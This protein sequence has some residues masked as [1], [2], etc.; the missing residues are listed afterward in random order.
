MKKALVSLVLAL[1]AVA[2]GC[3][4]DEQTI[5]ASPSKSVPIASAK[6]TAWLAAISDRQR[7]RVYVTWAVAYDDRP[8][9]RMYVAAS[10]DGGRTFGPP[11]W[12]ARD[13]SAWLPVIR[14]D[15]TGR[16]WATW[17]HFDLDPKHLLNPKDEYSNPAWQRVAY[18]DD[19]GTTWSTPVD[20][21][22]QKRS[23]TAFGTL[24]VAP[25]GKTVTAVWINYLFDVDVGHD[26]GT[27][28]SAT[29]RDGGRTFGPIREVVRAGC[30]CCE[31]FGF[32]LD[33]KAALA[34]RGWE[35]GTAKRAIRDI[36]LSIASAA[37]AW[38]A[39]TDVHDDNFL[40]EHCPS[41]GPAALVDGGG[42]T[43]FAWW[44]GA[45]DRAGYWY[46][47]RDPEG[48]MSEPILIEKHPSAPSENN[49]TLARGPGDVYLTATVGH[50]QY[51]AKGGEDKTPNHVD[52]YAI[53]AGGRVQ[54]LADA[55]VD[56][57]F[58][59]LAGVKDDVVQV[60]V[61]D[62]KIEARRLGVSG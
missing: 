2:A 48:Q 39:P 52:V 41:V 30:V 18:S 37:G 38:R 60:W 29:S 15:D 17:T 36:K 14:L 61:S 56:G 49:A 46:A 21:R 59:Q 44:T 34:F 19:A 10:E 11:V 24:A 54:R 16:L 4:S 27:Y 1:V 62:G 5:D 58:P 8:N 13:D 55:R 32:S 42:A 9:T 45:D 6:S 25:D 40:L 57:A 33:G 50:G 3:S 7:D 28:L 26:A 35:S 23:S 51:N 31:P 12:V 47:I 53:S 43:H 22:R 20:I